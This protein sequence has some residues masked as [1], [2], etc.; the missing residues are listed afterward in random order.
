MPRL[1]LRV[2]RCHMPIEARRPSLLIALPSHHLASHEQELAERRQL[3]HERARLAAGEALR[4]LRAER[5]R[6]TEHHD[7]EP[8]TGTPPAA[9]KDPAL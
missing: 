5:N 8:E 3:V 1:I 2:A 9:G 4:T 7:V 6:R